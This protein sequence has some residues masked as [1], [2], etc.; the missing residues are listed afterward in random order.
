MNPPDGSY[1]LNVTSESSSLEEDDAVTLTISYRVNA[2]AAIGGTV[3]FSIEG[4]AGVSAN[5]EAAEV[6]INTVSSAM[7]SIPAVTASTNAVSVARLKIEEQ[8]ASALSSSGD[9]R[10][11]APRGIRFV[12]GD[13]VITTFETNDTWQTSLSGTPG[14]DTRTVTPQEVIV[15]PSASPGRIAFSILDGDGSAD[16]DLSGV[17][18]EDVYL[19]YVGEVDDL[20]AGADITI[21]EGFSIS[22][23]VSGGLLDEEEGDEYSVTSSD[24]EVASAAV[25]GNTLTVTGV[26]IGAVTITVSDELGNT[27]S[28]AV[29][30]AAAGAAPDLSAV[31]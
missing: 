21:A 7:D 15:S 28:I 27:D 17:T 10:L 13:D 5:I 14:V 8:Y 24:D 29:D 25:S 22:Q 4:T 19:L 3:S 9:F 30:V 18:E 16:P 26:A 1:I 31:S 23:S 12:D 11:R 20:D 2:D 6:T